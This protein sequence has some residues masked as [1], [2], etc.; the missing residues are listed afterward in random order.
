M[1]KRVG[2][3]VFIFLIFFSGCL[4]KP[5]LPGKDPG[6]LY[7]KIGLAE[8]EK[9]STNAVSTEIEKLL[10]SL[11]SKGLKKEQLFEYVGKEL[12]IS[13]DNL[14]PGTWKIQVYGL[15][16][17]K[18]PIFYGESSI[19]IL[20]GQTEELFIQILPAPGRVN[21]T[22][23]ISEF[24][25]HGVEVLEGKFYVYLD[26]NSDRSTSFPLQLEGDYLKNTNEIIINEGTYQ[27]IIY[28]P[29]ITK[30]IYKSPY[31][32][33][34][35]K[36]GKLTEIYLEADANLIVN[37]IID[38]TPA[39]PENF[40]V[41]INDVEERESETKTAQLLI[42]WDPVNESDLAG[43]Y[44][45]RTNKEGRLKLLVKLNTDTIFF[46]DSITDKDFYYNQIGYAISSFD[47]G[48]NESFWTETHYI[49]YSDL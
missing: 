40:K 10:V 43:Y 12:V 36:A 30:Y 39:T 26:P 35:I 3:L 42:T 47:E 7:L 13:F 9:I 34:N 33:I 44:L 27:A 38:S 15:D 20:P 49:T 37:G 31:Q 24:L 23:D 28:I 25:N 16:Q 6:R 4:K 5:Y 22:I 48:G 1:E 8:T 18:D 41:I 46:E 45:Y 14:Y 32:T 2:L 19:E 29:Q 21:V 11:T 17:A